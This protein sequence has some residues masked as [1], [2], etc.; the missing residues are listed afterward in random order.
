MDIGKSITYIFEDRD[1]L[2]KVVIG[3]LI[4]LI[5][6]PLTVVV[7][8]FLG[9]AIVSGYGL[10][11]LKNVRQRKPQILPAWRDRWGEWL[12]LG[13]K[14]LVALFIW[15]LPAA[16]FSVPL[17][18]GSALTDSQG[19]EFL[20][21]ALILFFSCLTLLWT[22]VVILVSPAIYIRLA[23]TERLGSTLQ[24]GEIISFTREHIGDVLIAVIVYTLL[25]LAVAVVA[26]VVGAVLCLVG[27]IVT[28]PAGSFIS[29]LIQSHLYGQVGMG[30]LDVQ[31]VVPA[32]VE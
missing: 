19:A 24:F 1:W 11:V 27:L 25:S 18:L 28:I 30:T 13:L 2:S 8:G 12:V 6:M 29:M 10:D 20:G 4:L 5:S 16:L 21:V 22:F 9:V 7:V 32:E 14:L 31:E 15:S 26:S 23:E 3:T 17:S